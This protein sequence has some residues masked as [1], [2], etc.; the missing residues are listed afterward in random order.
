MRLD[1]QLLMLPLLESLKAGASLTMTETQKVL[2]RFIEQSD[3]GLLSFDPEKD[4][5]SFLDAVQLAKEHL[6]KAG[7]LEIVGVDEIRITSFGKMILSKRLNSID[8]EYLSRLPGY[9]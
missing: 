9:R 6:S 7:L 8:I 3:L 1:F 4:Q 5:Q 2:K